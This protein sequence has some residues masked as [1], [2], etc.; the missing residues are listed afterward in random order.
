MSFKTFNR[1]TYFL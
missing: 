1:K